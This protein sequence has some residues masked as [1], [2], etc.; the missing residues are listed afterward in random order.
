MNMCIFEIHSSENLRNFTSTSVFSS[1]IFLNKFLLVLLQST[2]TH[3]TYV[4]DVY[5]ILGNQTA[6]A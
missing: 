5:Y 3:K 6:K 2:F 1:E 4:P